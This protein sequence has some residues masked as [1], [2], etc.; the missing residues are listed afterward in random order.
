M[1]WGDGIICYK[2]EKMYQFSMGDL[3]CIISIKTVH[4]EVIKRII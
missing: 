4:I 3:G 1:G 2:T